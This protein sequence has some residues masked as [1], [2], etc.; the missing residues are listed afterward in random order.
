MTEVALML[1]QSAMLSSTL[2]LSILNFFRLASM[3]R[4]FAWC[5]RYQSMS[6][7]VSPAC[8]HTC[9]MLR[10]MA[11]TANLYTSPPSI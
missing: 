7:G 2:L 10:P 4:T 1:P 3:M 5:G 11:L 9:S 8:A 6:A